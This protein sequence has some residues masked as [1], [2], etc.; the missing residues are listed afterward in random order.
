MA[1]IDSHT[2]P[3]A[4]AGGKGERAGG[5]ASDDDIFNDD[6]FDDMRLVTPQHLR[7]SMSPLPHNSARLKSVA[8]KQE[9]YQLPPDAAK[10]FIAAL[11]AML[12][13]A[14]ESDDECEGEDAVEGE[15]GARGH[16]SSHGFFS[17]SHHT[18]NPFKHHN[19]PG[20][21]AAHGASG[22]DTGPSQEPLEDV[23]MDNDFMWDYEEM[24]PREANTSWDCRG[25]IRMQIRHYLD[26]I[27]LNG[28]KGD[29]IIRDRK[30]EPGTLALQIK[31]GPESYNTQAIDLT[32]VGGRPWFNLRRPDPTPKF[33]SVRQLVR[34]YSLAPREELDFIQLRCGSH[35]LTT[36]PDRIS[37]LRPISC[38]MNNG[39]GRRLADADEAEI[40]QYAPADVYSPSRKPHNHNTKMCTQPS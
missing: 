25:M 21:E 1:A 33:P 11:D 2:P 34:H 9:P 4:G 18:I 14:T 37:M 23:D 19:H 12:S 15:E 22:A 8:D 16:G 28:V 6:G 38:D 24:A 39:N 7:L 35:V 27:I 13:R 36:S 30:T 17:H 20:D 26:S 29:F 31:S 40:R 3:P 10:S 5:E 32:T